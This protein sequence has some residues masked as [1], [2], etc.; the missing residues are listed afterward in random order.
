MEVTLMEGEAPVI[1]GDVQPEPVN[2]KVGRRIPEPDD[3]DMF[4]VI[5]QHF[6]IQ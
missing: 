2:Q 3:F 6:L 1:Q 5:H 4:D